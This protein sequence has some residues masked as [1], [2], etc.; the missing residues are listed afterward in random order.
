MRPRNDVKPVASSRLAQKPTV[1]KKIP[2]E[3]TVG[4]IAKRLHVSLSEVCAAVDSLA[5]PV[6]L[7]EGGTSGK[8]LVRHYPSRYLRSIEMQIATM[9]EGQKKP[10]FTR[11]AP[12]EED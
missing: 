2:T 12:V 5:L 11:H 9:R 7:L 3:L 1:V 6:V 4:S 10:T 8:Q